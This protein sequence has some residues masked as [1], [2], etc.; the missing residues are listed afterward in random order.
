[1]KP[2]E[3]QYEA[4]WKGIR[5]TVWGDHYYIEEAITDLPR[6]AIQAIHACIDSKDDAAL[7]ALIRHY[8]DLHV[9]RETDKLYDEEIEDFDANFVGDM[10]EITR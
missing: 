4:F 6:P 3:T 2:S 5:E 1:M 7:G 10:M 8:I 9:D